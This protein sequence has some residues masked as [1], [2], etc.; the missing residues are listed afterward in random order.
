MITLSKTL[1]SDLQSHGEEAFPEECCGAM[2]GRVDGVKKL[3]N[4]LVRLD[5]KWED[6][7]TET[8][9][10]RFKVGPDDYQ[11]L[12]SMAKKEQTT[13]LGFYHT[14]PNHPAV[15]SETDA[16]YAWPFFSYIILSVKNGV[17]DDC[18]S[19]L[20][21]FDTRQFTKEVLKFL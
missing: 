2:F 13:L 3:V 12:E 17:S 16:L 4:K 10:R 8:K 5:N 14:H 7:Q 6:T 15:P 9:Y 19:Y 18:F 1:F 11:Y 21:D 20:F